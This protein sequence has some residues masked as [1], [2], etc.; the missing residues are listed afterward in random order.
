MKISP[1]WHRTGQWYFSQVTGPS[2]F[3]PLRTYLL[4]VVFLLWSGDQC[5]ELFNEVS[6]LSPSWH[7]GHGHNSLEGISETRQD[8]PV[9]VIIIT[10]E[11]CIYSKSSFLRKKKKIFFL[12]L[13]SIL[14]VSSL[15]PWTLCFAWSFSNQIKF[16][17]CSAFHTMTCNLRCFRLKTKYE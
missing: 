4:S 3:R 12:L 14:H 10:P 6:V 1:L 17:L 13:L 7:F 16:Y 15:S 2:P 5:W 9:A 8:G 11:R